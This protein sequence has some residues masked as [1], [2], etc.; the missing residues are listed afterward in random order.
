MVTVAAVWRLIAFK[1]ISFLDDQIPAAK[2]EMV[3]LIV[4]R[5]PIYYGRPLSATEY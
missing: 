3:R 5:N 2:E 4:K 1:D